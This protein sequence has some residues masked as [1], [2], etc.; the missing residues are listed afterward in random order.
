MKKLDEKRKLF[1]IHFP[2]SSHALFMG[3][4]ILLFKTSARTINQNSPADK[5]PIQT[6]LPD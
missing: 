3:L 2:F 5:N 6:P 1:F 4:F